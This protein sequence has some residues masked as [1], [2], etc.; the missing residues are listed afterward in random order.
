MPNGETSNTTKKAL[1]PN[2]NLNP[3]ARELDILPDLKENSLL[4]VCKLSDAGY[5]AIFHPG[6]GGVTVYWH[7]DVYI[8]VKK[9]AVLK[10]WRDESGLWRVPIKDDV[11]NENTDTLILQ[12]P[13]VSEAVSN[14][15]N[16]P[17]TEKNHQ[18]SPRCIRFPHKSN[19]VESNQ[20]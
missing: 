15:S 5:T 12:R 20:K 11:K 16:L 19:N 6:D 17:S 14:V 9:E 4:S 2:Q 1:L 3:Q 8:R 7:D 13:A 18:I 10:G